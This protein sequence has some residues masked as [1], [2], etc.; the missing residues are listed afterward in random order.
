MATTIRAPIHAHGEVSFAKFLFL[1]CWFVKLLE[2]KFS[3]FA[4]IRWVTNWF[5]KLLELLLGQMTNTSPNDLAFECQAQKMCC[6][7]RIKQKSLKMITNLWVIRGIQNTLWLLRTLSGKKFTR[8][9]KDK[10][11]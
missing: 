7:L 1:P 8:R 11:Y 5:T 6:H 4:K 2:A 10:Q 9:N 3:R